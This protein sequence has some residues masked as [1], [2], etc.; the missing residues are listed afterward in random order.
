MVSTPGGLTT[1]GDSRKS[2]SNTR[3]R[4]S[5]AREGT[6]IPAIARPKRRAAGGGRQNIFARPTWKRRPTGRARARSRSRGPRPGC[7]RA[8]RDGRGGRGGVDGREYTH[9][10]RARD[11]DDGDDCDDGDDR[12]RRKYLLPD[13]SS[14][15]PTDHRASER[16]TDVFV[17]DSIRLPVRIVSIIK[18]MYGD[19][20]L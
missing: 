15:P 13:A 2:I 19:K 16:A 7:V 5:R 3:A 10:R 12:E 20:K 14:R 17:C 18:Y 8:G 11:G 9:A 4:I 1:S 6:R